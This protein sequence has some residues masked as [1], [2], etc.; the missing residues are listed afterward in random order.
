MT[1]EERSFY[2][3]MQP[4]GFILMGRNCQSPEQVRALVRDLRACVAHPDAPV[5]IDMEGGRVARLKPPLWPV[6]PSAALI[7]TLYHYDAALGIEMAGLAGNLIGQTLHELGITV[8]CAPVLDVAHPETHDAIGDRAFSADPRAVGLLG[9][10]F[11]EGLLAAGVLP[12]I[13]HLPGHGYAEVDPH[14]ALPT[15]EEDAETVMADFAPFRMLAAMPIGMTSH[16][17]FTAFDAE[18][19]ASQSPLIVR[20]IIRRAVGFNGLLL[21]DDLDMKALG[22]DLASRSA[23]V[24]AAGTDAL[25]ICN[26]PVA[27]LAPYRD[28]PP[29]TTMAWQRW[30]RAHR[31]LDGAPAQK[32]DQA[33]Q[34]A[35]LSVLRRL[36]E[37]QGA[38]TAAVL[39]G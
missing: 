39:Q 20:D 6:F 17:V 4:L 37:E 1:E 23:K 32:P 16:V 19:P 26:T 11:A 2:Q 9:H 8:D 7:G 30:E 3:A 33:A 35:R 34:L 38:R 31:F 12:V 21:S 10:A 22:G 5:L 27:E 18:L 28:L 15:V 13:K 25:L 24:L 36:A 14:L 29:M